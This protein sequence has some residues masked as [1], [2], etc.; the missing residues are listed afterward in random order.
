[1]TTSFSFTREPIPRDPLPF[2]TASGAVLEFWGVVRADEAGRTIPGLDYEAHEPMA[3]R[4]LE[5]IASELGRLHPVA[6]VRMV[7]RL[8]RVPA[9]EA[10]LWL[11][12]ASGHRGEAIEFLRLFI[13]SLKA[14]VPVWKRIPSA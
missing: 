6:A 13:E 3:R 5:R 10:S 11:A 9:G 14:D 1:M 2:D 8:G 4:H 12:V 7:H